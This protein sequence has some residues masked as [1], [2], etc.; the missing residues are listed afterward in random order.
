MPDL[1]YMRMSVCEAGEIYFPDVA[2]CRQFLPY[3][4]SICSNI[5]MLELKTHC[6]LFL[7]D[8]C[9]Y[10]NILVDGCISDLQ[11]IWTTTNG[12]EWNP[13]II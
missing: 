2:I 4:N 1:L 7:V 8:L 5:C 11:T 10:L 9:F 13:V 12:L 3:V 6:I